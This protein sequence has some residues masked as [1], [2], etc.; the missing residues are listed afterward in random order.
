MAHLGFLLGLCFF[1]RPM[2]QAI[3]QLM[4]DD[5]GKPPN[6]GPHLG[7]SRIWVK[8]VLT[9]IPVLLEAMICQC[10]QTFS[11][12]LILLVTDTAR[13]VLQNHTRWYQKCNP[14]KLT[15]P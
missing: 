1:T 5:L 10:D 3:R 12:G 2:F 11:C 9:I 4:L 15:N 13:I 7:R 6:Y 8:F 14:T